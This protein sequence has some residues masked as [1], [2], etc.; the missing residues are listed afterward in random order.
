MAIS[1]SRT[2][3]LPPGRRGFP[4]LG[5]TGDWARDPLKFARDRHARYG[6]VWRTHL[7]GRPT[8]VLLGP[9]A[10]RFI[11]GTHM[12][13]FS[14]RQGWSKTI[15]SLIGDGL[16]L[17]DGATHRRHRAMIMPAL[18]GAVLQG[19]AAEMQAQVAGH[20]QQWLA[21]GELRLFDGFKRLSFDI[22]TRLMLGP[23]LQDEAAECFKLFRTF[24]RG[25][26]APPAWR[27]P[28]LPYGRAW[29]AGQRL[30][31]I[32]ARIVAEHRRAPADTILGTLVAA[33]DEAGEGFSD[34]ELMD[35]LLVLLW[36]GH[37]TITSL[38]TWV[39]YELARHPAVDAEA[40]AEQ[41]ALGGAA[42]DAAALKR[43]PAL[44]RV[45]R[46]AE[47]LHPPAPGGFRAVVEEFE[48]GGFHIPAGW[49]VMYS[50]VFTHH[51]PELWHDPE[52]FDPARFAAPRNEGRQ[53]FCMVGFGGGPRVCVGLAFA[54]MQMRIVMAYLLRNVR[55]ELLPGQRFD[56]VAV[57]T[58]MPRDG[59]RVRVQRS[60]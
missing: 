28:W 12:H 36:A 48:Y 2:R 16:S 43:M 53:P 51:M 59:L 10:N 50:S 26:F 32:L 20:A 55:F 5:E 30:R 60:T 57:P 15:T 1:M 17:L 45:L 6:P 31:P 4:V 14:S 7:M 38:L 25:L 18:H 52:C 23:Q 27:L 35:E 47:R 9:E 13:L 49:N 21:L 34:A 8:A 54:Q 3:P 41:L 11:L 56:P 58:R 33:R 22:A 39:V 40:R 29:D 44:D 19:Y 42:L 37:D 24:T 46:E